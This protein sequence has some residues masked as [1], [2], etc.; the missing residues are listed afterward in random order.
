MM[1][2]DYCSTVALPNTTP[3]WRY[4]EGRQL[5]TT[6]GGGLLFPSIICLTTYQPFTFKYLRGRIIDIHIVIQSALRS[7][8]KYLQAFPCTELAVRLHSFCLNA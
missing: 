2:S 1:M 6:N 4:W 8:L 7:N 3:E 5:Q